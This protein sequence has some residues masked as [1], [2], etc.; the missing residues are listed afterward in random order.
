MVEAEDDKAANIISHAAR[1][2]FSHSFI[3]VFP[4]FK[5]LLDGRAAQVAAMVTQGAL[6]DRV[7]IAVK[8][9]TE[10]FVKY[11]VSGQVLFED[12]LLKEPRRM[13]DV[14]FCG[15]NV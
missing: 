13:G 2:Q 10:I 9:E 1:D 7:V 3:D 12:H 11:L 14:P 4:I 5:N 6:A 15:R 8:K